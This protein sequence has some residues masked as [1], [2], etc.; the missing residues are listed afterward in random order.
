MSITT[1][2]AVVE[3]GGAPFT[4][5]DVVLDEPGPHEAVVRMVAAGLCHTDLGAAGGGLPF[6]L[7]G[8][9]GHEGA[10]VV[11]AVGS[12]VTGIAPGD[13]V[14]LSFTS[15][16]ACG[17][18]DGGHPAY[19]AS[20]LPLNL[21]G[22]R[23]ADGT[24]T[25]A[26]DGEPLGGHFFGQ[27]SFAE[28]ALVDDR[29]LV[30]VDA[31]VPLESI[32]P[33]G[34]GV[35]TGVGAVWN[36]LKPVTGSTIVVLGAGAVGL[37]AVMAAALTPATTVVAVDRVGERLALAKELGATHTVNAGERDLGEAL[38]EITGGRGADGVVE[39]TGNVGV[40]RQGVDA[41]AARG[42]VVVVGAPPF[43]TE[44]ALD[45]N[46]LLGGKRV[47]GLTLGD[48]ETQTFIPALVELVKTGRLPLH[49]LIS[50]YPFADIDQAVRDMAAGKA[51]KPVLTF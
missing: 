36:V 34:C 12:A 42:T 20:W 51:I 22:G 26:R 15:C 2:A 44:V 10:G 43:G 4:L 11:E 46:G 32:A 49:R 14:V 31:D 30:K 27:S 3:S 38:A 13:H 29:S 21:I 16:G 45:V 28:R 47:V 1:R 50:T 41:L 24:S 19:C 40:L 6:P 9:L 35:Q 25:I 18:C 33:L 37:S 8:V 5:C 17:N 23:R 48:A 39:T 7:P